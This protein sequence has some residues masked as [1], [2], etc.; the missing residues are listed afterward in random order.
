MIVFVLEENNH[1]TLG[2]VSSVR[3]AA[4]FLIKKY[5][6]CPASDVWDEEAS[7]FAPFLRCLG[8]IGLIL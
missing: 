7:D 3:A 5:W 2:V 6:L 1:G 4:E 8:R